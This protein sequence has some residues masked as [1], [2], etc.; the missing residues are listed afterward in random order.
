MP[1]RDRGVFVLGAIGAQLKS[2]HPAIYLYRSV[3]FS[4]MRRLRL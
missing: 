4:S 3:S 1:Q 2:A